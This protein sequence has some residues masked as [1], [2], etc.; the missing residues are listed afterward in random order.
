[1][2]RRGLTP[3]QRLWRLW[4]HI[5]PLGR[6]SALRPGASRA[7][8]Y[9]FTRRARLVLSLAQEEARRRGQTDIRP[10]HLLLGLLRE[11][12]GMGTHA[13]KELGVDLDAVRG[14][15]DALAS[16]PSRAPEHDGGMRLT[17]ASKRVIELA[18]NEGRALSHPYGGTEHILL[19]LLAEGESVAAQALADMGVTRERAREAVLAVLRRR[20]DYG[21]RNEWL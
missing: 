16:L 5:R 21:V 8:F 9:G 20:P 3:Y 18:V 11:R 17:E 13:L 2:E 12:K 7:R 14:R 10:E 1:M 15:V 19:G 6:N 4:V